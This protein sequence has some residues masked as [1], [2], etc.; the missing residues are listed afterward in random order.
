MVRAAQSDLS[1]DANAT[2][3]ELSHLFGGRPLPQIQLVQALKFHFLVATVFP[4]HSIIPAYRRYQIPALPEIMVH[5]I[6]FPP[7]IYPRQADRVLSFM[8]PTT[9]NTA[10]FGG[11]EIRT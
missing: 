6:L 8:Y 3:I 5:I 10:Y 2:L 1:G 9:C 11:I 7:P 4:N